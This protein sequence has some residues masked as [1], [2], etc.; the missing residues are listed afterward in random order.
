MP[1]HDIKLLNC[2]LNVCNSG[3]TTPVINLSKLSVDLPER[4][5]PFN[6]FSSIF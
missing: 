4:D 1:N 5:Y 2:Q 3:L 6:G